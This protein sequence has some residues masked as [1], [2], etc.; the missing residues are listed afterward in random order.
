LQK[1]KKKK[2]FKST[3]LKI[4]AGKLEPAEGGE[5]LPQLSVSFKP[6]DVLFPSSIVKKIKKIKKKIIIKNFPGKLDR[7]RII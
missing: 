1:K 5:K 4:L 7:K 6:Q 2:N 3:F